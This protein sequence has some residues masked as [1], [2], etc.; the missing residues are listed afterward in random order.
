MIKTIPYTITAETQVHHGSDK[1]TSN[2]SLFRR[3]RINVRPQEITSHFKTDESRRR[4]IVM[5]LKAIFDS[6]PDSRRSVKIWD[7]FSSKV[8]VAAIQA[9][10]QYAFLNNIC[11]LFGIGS[12]H[13]PD[14]VDVLSRF[15]ANEFLITL[16]DELH[17]LVSYMR[18]SREEKAS[19]NGLF[20]DP[21][22]EQPVLIFKKKYED[23]PYISGNGIR[24][25]LRRL[26]LY[27][28]FERIGLTR[29]V[30]KESD[31]DRLIQDVE[32][33][34][35]MTGGVITDGGGFEDVAK[36][37]EYLKMC[38]AIGLFGSVNPAGSGTIRGKLAVG[39]A[40]LRCSENLSGG[41]SFYSKLNMVFH[42]HSD[43][44]KLET[45]VAIQLSEK[46]QTVQMIYYHEVLIAG[47]VF[48]SAFK[49]LNC[50]P[51][52]ESC[53]WY[54]LSLWKEKPTIGGKGAIDFG[55]ISLGY[56]VPNGAADAYLDYVKAN[57]SAMLDYFSVKA[58]VAG[59]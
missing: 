16:R 10:S 7:E 14:S 12:L 33:H 3:Q 29:D 15:D 40:K 20:A 8:Y 27:D 2:I 49:L 28:F 22:Q 11:F 48:D 54:G 13:K 46:P 36:K 9:Q 37:E 31:L 55:S 24:G 34:R 39:E 59:K 43:S 50:Q 44:S 18:L 21:E 17:Y 30:F 53:F 42:T 58:E 38:P 1:K 45:D 5:V 56:E 23:A 47:S 35:L 4:A 32:Y 6:I 41:E 19:L 52:L 51:L 25:P 26:L 57:K